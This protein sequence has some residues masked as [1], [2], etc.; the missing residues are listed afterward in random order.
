M[1]FEPTGDNG[2]AL[3]LC[4][5]NYRI[6]NTHLLVSSVNTYNQHFSLADP[7]FCTPKLLSPRLYV[8]VLNIFPANLHAKLTT[9]PITPI[10]TSHAHTFNIL[11]IIHAGES[12]DICKWNAKLNYNFR[13]LLARLCF[14][15]ASNGATA[16]HTV[17]FKTLRQVLREFSLGSL[18]SRCNSSVVWEV[19][20]MFYVINRLC[21]SK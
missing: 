17:K 19:T 7:C 6:H 1:L 15:Y 13:D 9:E 12:L 21:I 18:R 16:D 10:A 5:I 20:M 14:I 2:I 4:Y 11:L 8:K 3:K